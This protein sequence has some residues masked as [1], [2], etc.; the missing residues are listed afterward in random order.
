MIQIISQEELPVHNCYIALT[1]GT[2]E[3]SHI[4]QYK[5]LR[6]SAKLLLPRQTPLHTLSHHVSLHRNTW[7]RHQVHQV[8][9][10]KLRLLEMIH[11]KQPS[12]MSRGKNW[13][14]SKEPTGRPSSQRSRS[15][16]HLNKLLKKKI[17]IAIHQLLA[18]LVSVHKGTSRRK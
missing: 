10:L 6:S 2:S 12:V 13:D 17:T 8:S 14:L 15:P 18:I 1:E 3:C 7:A 9:F 16:T 11:L 5:G 4:H